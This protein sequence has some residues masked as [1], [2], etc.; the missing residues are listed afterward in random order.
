MKDCGTDSILKN[1]QILG[2]S[3]ELT[4]LPHSHDDKF[5]KPFIMKLQY[6]PKSF[7]IQQVFDTHWLYATLAPLAKDNICDIFDP[8]Y[9]FKGR[10]V[11]AG[12]N[13]PS[14]GVFQCQLSQLRTTRR[15]GGKAPRILIKSNIKYNFPFT[16]RDAKGWANYINSHNRPD[17]PVLLLFSTGRPLNGYPPDVHFDPPRCYILV[18]GLILSKR[19]LPEATT[20]FHPRQLSQRFHPQLE[21]QQF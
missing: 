2:E 11:N 6:P 12:T 14:V 17:E 8:S 19:V 10:Y 7:Q 18:V 1:F 3:N 13:C 20:A 5:V 4:L 21:S 16:A 9:L 15:P